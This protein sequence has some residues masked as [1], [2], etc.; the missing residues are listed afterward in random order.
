[1]RDPK[2]GS[3]SVDTKA[4]IDETLPIERLIVIEA[5]LNDIPV[6]ALKDD[7]C[8]TN[9]ISR[10]F[11]ELHAELFDVVEKKVQVS[12]SNKEST[13]VATKIVVQAKLVCGTHV[14]HSNFA[15]ANCRYDVLLGMPW[16][17]ECKPMIRY[18]IPTVAVADQ[19]LPVEVDDSSGPVISNIGVKKF[20]SML[21]KKGSREDFQVLGLVE[22]AEH[23][24]RNEGKAS[25][26]QELD[27][28]LYRYHGVFKEELPDGLPPV[29]S[30]DHAIETEDGAKPPMRPLY[31][32]SPAEL[33]AV[34]TYVVDL[35][36][37][38]KIRRSKSPYGAYLFFVKNKGA[39]RAVVDYRALNRLTKRNR[40]PLPRT[41]EM[42]DRLGEARVFSKIDLKTG[43]HQIRVRPEDIEKTA[44][45]TKYGQ[46]E[47]LVMPMGL[48]DAPATFQTLMN[49]IFY[50]CIDDFIVVYM[51]DLLI[52]SKTPD[53]HLRHLE[54]V[55]SRLAEKKLY[56]APHKCQFME[57]ETEFLGLIVG[58]NGIRVNPEKVAVLRDWPK[59]K[60]LTE[61]RSFIGLLQFFRRFIKGFSEVAAPLTGLT[62]KGKGIAAWDSTCDDSFNTLKQAITTSPILTSPNWSRPFRC[63]VDASQKA[64]GGTLTQLDEE[65]NK[66]V[67]AFFS[68]RLSEVEERYT[69]NERE[70]LGL[71]YFLKRFRCYL[72]GSSFEV[73][74]DNQVLSNFFT[75]PNMSRKEARWLDL[76]SQFGISKVTLKAGRVHVLG[77]ALSR[78]PH[79]VEGPETCIDANNME[80][81][82]VE[83]G[84]DFSEHYEDDQ[85]FG[86]VVRALKGTFPRDKISKDR[87]SRI[88]H[89]FRW[90]NRG[91]VYKGKL[92]VPRRCVRDILYEAHDSKIAGHFAFGKTLARLAHFHWKSKTRD[93]LGYCAGCETCQ[94]QKDYRNK[95]KYTDPTPLDIPSRRWGSLATDFIV[96]LPKTKRGFDCITTWVD[97]LSR[98][99]HF[100][101]SHTTDTATD[102]A[103]S[104]FNNIFKLHGLP[105]NIVSD[106]D[107]KFTSKF[108]K[109][110][111]SLCG[112]RCQMSS[113]HHPQT[114][115]AS[116]VMNRMVE[117]Y[118][119]CYCS[120]HQDDWDILLPAAEFTYN[121]AES[122]D[123]SA[124]PFEVDLGWKPRS[125]IDVLY[126]QSVPVES[127]NQFKRQLRSAL[128]DAQFAHEL[129]KARNSAQSAKKFQPHPYKVGDQV[130][131]AK[132]LFRD[133]IAKVQKSDKLTP[134]RYGPFTILELIGKNALRLDLPSNLRLYPVVHALHT[135]PHRKQPI[136]LS[137]PVTKR[138]VPV[139]DATGQE[140][141]EVAE[142]FKHRKRGRG[143][144]F[145]TLL[146]GVPRHEAVWQPTKDF[147][148][149]DG[150]LTEVF[151][152]YIRK[153]NLLPQLRSNCEQSS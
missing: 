120:I 21:R 63:H 130:W 56:V 23:L 113:S 74:T 39:L 4:L 134:K 10:D 75:K 88:L 19:H 85:L 131:V 37:K 71:V 50:D 146:K 36:R 79:V 46:F 129:A 64:V 6:R 15:V 107:P 70:L 41:D 73:F 143:Y 30:V 35:L 127:V 52:Y 93:V 38:G 122:K 22:N 68:K 32:L 94:Q 109:H 80:V 147:V 69:A 144:Q 66:R 98:R 128:E 24:R 86:P 87:L 60:S 8:N 13:E 112:I 18:E 17:V 67:V 145:L 132:E 96:K 26:S 28:L 12:H 82:A 76:L 59:P 102:V 78:A 150:T 89:L 58:C 111:M 121:S 137:Q 47:Y 119:R 33:V 31:Q 57:K 61:V 117:N 148:D 45:N 20:R 136:S 108:W 43:F 5:L 106:R 2:L 114:D 153:H 55:L 110:L 42:F 51:D 16:H 84:I 34:R 149:T 25:H 124:S 95:K 11:F 105:D 3:E 141:H 152:H 142:I 116:E 138:P 133:A 103:D 125:P 151:Y 81:N 53:E 49:E 72:E 62:R 27:N 135:T 91:L 7:G 115:G 104:F 1:M 140:L 118:L 40:S 77:D 48:C 44:F 123:L 29:R 90:Q 14:Y 100:I 92:C 83:W 54:V 65:G 97:R 101:P 126:G 139:P 99:V 9:V